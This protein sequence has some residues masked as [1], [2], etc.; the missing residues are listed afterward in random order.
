MGN[1]H[2]SEFWTYL[3][4]RYAGEE[5]AGR[6]AAARLPMGAEEARSLGLVDEV[7][8]G[9]F[10]E[11]HENV[12]R[13]AR[14]LTRDDEFV[15]RLERKRWRRRLDDKNKPLQQY[16]EE[17]LS[18]MHLNFYGFDPSYHVARYNF[19]Y[20]VPKSRTPLT[21]ARHRTGHQTRW[22]VS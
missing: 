1:L 15:P 6:I 11:F 18:R 10:H 19:V 21:L 12:R 22:S 17:E 4:P 16:R 5:N 8:S 14:E 13:R 2:G 3:L 9:H 20:K 7:I